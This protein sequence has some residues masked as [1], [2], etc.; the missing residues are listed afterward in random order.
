MSDVG[1]RFPPESGTLSGFFDQHADRQF[2]TRHCLYCDG[3]G[4]TAGCAGPEP[5]EECDGTGFKYRAIWTTEDGIT[6]SMTGSGA[7]PP[8]ANDRAVMELV[9]RAGFN[10][11]ES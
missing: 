7:T 10:R 1:H 2:V 5:C 4:A 11:S 3:A 6:C 8:D 9:A